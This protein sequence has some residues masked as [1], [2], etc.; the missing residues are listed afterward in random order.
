[1]NA[2][3]HK[4]DVFQAVAD[5]T[6]REVLQLLSESS[7][8]IA[9]L[10]SHFDVSRTAVVKHLNVLTKAG[11]VRGEKNGREKIYYLQPEPL[12][13][14]KDWLAYYEKFWYNKLAKLKYAVEN[15]TLNK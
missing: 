6:R 10:S 8:S 12:Q 5:P 1:M 4:V 14:L 7:Q 11:L 13:E 3:A 9:E 2:E 15:D